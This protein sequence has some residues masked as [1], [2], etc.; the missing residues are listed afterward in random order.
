MEYLL[1]VDFQKLESVEQWRT[2]N[3][4][5]SP[6]KE[7]CKR[8]FQTFAVNFSE[9]IDECKKVISG[10]GNPNYWEKL[11]HWE[12]A[13]GSGQQVSKYQTNLPNSLIRD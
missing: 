12:G 9:F 11:Y 7:V 2:G 1:A 13:K 3:Y 5:I 6:I 10:Q 4:L 8:I